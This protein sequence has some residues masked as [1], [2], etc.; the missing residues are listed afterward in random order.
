MS[1]TSPRVRA[2]SGVSVLERDAPFL[3]WHE[4]ALA[5]LARGAE[6][7]TVRRLTADDLPEGLRP[8]WT[9]WQIGHGLDVPLI[10]P[11]GELLGAPWL[12]RPAEWSESD[13]VLAERLADCYARRLARARL[14]ARRC[15]RKRRWP[16]IAAG[17]AAVGLVAR[18]RASRC[19]RARWP[20]RRW[21]PPTRGWSPRRWTG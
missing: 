4:T 3:R 21:S 18:A 7:R 13:A 5:A 14:G 10:A 9:E 15:R 8:G 16:R 19:R 6:A 2:I 12:S 17:A 11:D 20:R 1:G